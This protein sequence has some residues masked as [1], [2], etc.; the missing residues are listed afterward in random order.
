MATDFRRAV[1]VH[2]LTRS[3]NGR[4]VLDGLDLS[5][6]AGRFTALLGPRGSGRSTLLRVLAGLDREVSGTVL[7]PRHRALVSPAPRRTPWQRAWRGGPFGP[8]GPRASLDR[9]LRKDPDLLLL[10]DPFG[11]L[12]A[13]AASAARRR[14]GAWWQRRGGTVLLVTD[15]VDEALLLADRVLVLRGGVIAYDTPAAL[16]RQRSP[17]DPA[18]AAQRLRLLAELGAVAGSPVPRAA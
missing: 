9:A 8:P 3:F 17:A 5:L 14:V 12:D 4:A 15:D 2:G 13:R 11:A 7:V 16:D 10:D 1:T 18:F 6:A